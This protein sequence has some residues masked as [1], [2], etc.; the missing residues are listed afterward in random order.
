MSSAETIATPGGQGKREGTGTVKGRGY[1]YD[2]PQ[3]RLDTWNALHSRANWLREASRAGE[4]AEETAVEVGELLT[5]LRV[6]E[7]YWAFPGVGIV[8]DLKR[9]LT[10]RK[11][12]ELASLASESSRSLLSGKYRQALEPWDEEDEGRRPS[13]AK[14]GKTGRDRLY[15]EAL[16]VDAVDPEER[17]N[18]RDKLVGCRRP[19]DEFA[20]DLVFAPTIE[21][22]VIAVLFNHSIQSCVIRYGVPLRSSR[23]CSA[24]DRYLQMAELPTGQIGQGLE[25]S[26]AIART[27]RTLRPELDL[28]L[29][30]DSPFEDV[31]GALGG[32]F[33]RAFYRLD[34]FIELHLS[35]LKGI[36]ERY[37]TPFF[38]ALRRYSRKPTGVFHALP[39]SRGKSIDNSHWI[40]D[41]G[42]FYGRNI[43]LAE[44]SSTAGGLD[45]LLQP[46]GPIKLAQERA[47]TAFGAQRTYFVT[48][49]TSTA[50]K[51]VVQAMTRPGDIVLL[52]H[53]C[54]KSH[55]YALVLAGGHALYL[56]PYPMSD[57]TMYGGV[58][59]RQIKER[60]LELKRAG[61]LDRV[62]M[63]LL[64]NCTFDGI[65]YDPLRVMREVLAIKP[66][67]IFLWDEAWFAYGRFSPTLR[68]RSGMWAAR[69]LRDELRSESHRERYAAWRES[70]DELDPDDDATW[71]DQ[72]LMPDPY[73][74][75]VR[76][77]ATQSTHK[78]LTSL[79]QGSMIH[80]F[81]QDFEHSAQAPFD[82]A[83]MTHTSTSPNYQ[84]LASL[85]VGRRQVELEG[86]ELVQRSIG[87]AMSLRERIYGHPSIS[88][89]FSVLRPADMIPA[90]HRESGIEYYYDPERG[91]ADMERSWRS[92]EFILDPTRVTVHVGRTG[93]D[94]N[95]FRHLLMDQHDIQI[96]KTSRNSALFLT[97]IGQSRGDVAQLV[98]V[99]A[100]VS[101]SLDDRAERENLVERRQHAERVASLTQELPPLPN[102]SRWHA[103]FASPD[104]KTPEGDLRRAFYMAADESAVEYIDLGAG[105]DRAMAEGREVVSAAFV[106]PYPPG[107]PILAPGQV[108]SAEILAYLRAVDVKEIHGYRAGFGLR[109]FTR[110]VLEAETDDGEDAP[111]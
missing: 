89:Y 108:L 79:R 95:Q 18:V 32:T 92:D 26:L 67:M 87:L 40:S 71:L 85:D 28:F 86:Y 17:E 4:D 100:R 60:L 98:E 39:I 109:I 58:P 43:F 29:V 107:F 65:T 56:D 9:A 49:G 104:G 88:R 75:K 105:I 91:W 78:T 7:A 20:Y 101:D 76:V 64:T 69:T 44:T 22:A 50:N 5:L 16:F 68:Q 102:F 34:N 53:D 54:H 15:F 41:M 73:Q 37:E 27:L 13:T 82:E 46:H 3:L 8:D 42:D 36:R 33:R 38:D 84:I 97:N 80:V 24:F 2:A 62:R 55:L 63:L 110:A 30:T 96:N 48:N 47:A 106:T 1:Q 103:L 93:L 52:S 59:L 111:Q 14:S 21:D 45:S 94:G 90:E 10:T 66:D 70:F 31:A 57:Y 12:D 81:D 72:R 99:L 74:S 51:I 6:L 11:F 25:R 61:R 83:F 23:Q 77:Y 35:M 19:D